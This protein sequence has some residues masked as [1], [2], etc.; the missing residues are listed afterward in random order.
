MKFEQTILVTP[1]TTRSISH[2]LIFITF[3]LF[4][5]ATHL[6]TV[7]VFTDF[8]S[9][10]PSLPL[11]TTHFLLFT[12]TQTLDLIIVVQLKKKVFAVM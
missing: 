8:I 2:F 9:S 1:S 4:L 10:S 11:Q 3:P 5:P 6:I 7:M 12:G